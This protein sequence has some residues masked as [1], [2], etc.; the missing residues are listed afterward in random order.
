M[1]LVM[2]T[3]ESAIAAQSDATP[4]PLRKP[5][6]VWVQTLDRPEEAASY[7]AEWERLVSQAEEANVFYEP[8]ML[9]PAWTNFG[10]PDISLHLIWREPGRPTETR[11]L[12][13]L[14]PIERAKRF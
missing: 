10:S 13:G 4:S 7:I 5:G 11:Q 8:W 14:I 2:P 12:I 9:L 3:P 1:N 6:E